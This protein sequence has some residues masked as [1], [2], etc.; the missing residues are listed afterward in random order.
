MGGVVGVEAFGGG[1]VW[2]GL[3]RMGVGCV[4]PEV[5]FE[6][7]QDMPKSTQSSFCPP[8]LIAGIR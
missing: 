6:N 2:G 8:L 3:L 7:S 4:V 5:L 1:W